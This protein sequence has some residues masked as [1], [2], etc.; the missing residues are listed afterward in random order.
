MLNKL[1]PLNKLDDFWFFRL[2]ARISGQEFPQPDQQF[3]DYISRIEQILGPLRGPAALLTF[4]KWHLPA[5]LMGF[6]AGYWH[7]P[8]LFGLVLLLACSPI[9]FAIWWARTKGK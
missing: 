3:L 8:R 5:A 6:L 9:L 7:E 1:W 4:I 2:T